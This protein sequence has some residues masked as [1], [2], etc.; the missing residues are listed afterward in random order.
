MR[1]RLVVLLGLAL[2]TAPVRPAQAS[3]PSFLAKV[4]TRAG[5]TSDFRGGFQQPGPQSEASYLYD[6][7]YYESAPGVAITGADSADGAAHAGLGVLRVRSRAAQSAQGGTF[8]YYSTTSEAIVYAEFTVDD[9]VVRPTGPGA[10][11]FVFALLRFQIDGRMPEPLGQGGLFDTFLTTNFP[12]EVFAGALTELRVWITLKYPIGQSTG[13][14]QVRRS[15][16]T[17]YAAGSTSFADFSGEFF[18]K[19]AALESGQPFLVQAGFTGVPVGERLGL[20]VALEARSLSTYGFPENGGLFQGDAQVLL[21]STMTFATDFVA[22]LPPGLTLDSESAGIVDNVWVPEPAG[23]PLA[24]GGALA[25][26]SFARRGPRS[27]RRRGLLRST[28]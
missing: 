17:T 9:V 18:G 22:T 7:I 14:G 15:T 16:E 1:S 23:A 3:P 27:R 11:Q 20:T 28:S 24:S 25:L 10:P 12:N 26:L 5:P 21:D 19:E 8:Q 4:Y 2:A 6:P 13:G